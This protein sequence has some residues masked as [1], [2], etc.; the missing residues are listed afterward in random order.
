MKKRKYKLAIL[1]V[2]VLSVFLISILLVYTY[3]SGK[4]IDELA[5]YACNIDRKNNQILS[6]ELF[7]DITVETANSWSEKLKVAGNALESLALTV[8]KQLTKNSSSNQNGNGEIKLTKEKGKNYFTNSSQDLLSIFYWGR[9]DYVPQKIIRQLLSLKEK[10]DMFTGVINLYPETFY[11]VYVLSTD[12]FS[13]TYPQVNKYYKNIKDKKFFDRYYKFY[14]FPMEIKDKNIK[15]LLPCQFERPYRDISGFITMGV[16]V[17]IYDKGKMIALSSM[18]FNFEKIREA[19]LRSKLSSGIENKNERFSLESFFFLLSKGGSIITFPKQYADLFSL[20]KN[21]LNIEDFLKENTVNFS[22][23]RDPAIKTLGTKIA[24]NDFGVE[25]ITINNQA[26]MIAFATIKETGWKLGYVIKNESLLTSTVATEELINSNV[27]K[28]FRSY[29]WI[30]AILFILSFLILYFIFRYYVLRP[31]NRIKKGIC[32]MGEGNFNINLKEEGAAE[33]VELSSA[34]NY[35]GKELKDYMENLKIEITARQDF[36]TEIKIAEK[37]QRS[38][39]P[40]AASF[41]TNGNFQLVSRLNPAKNVSGDFY[42]FFYINDK[43]MALIIA[44]VSGKSLQAAF[45]MATSKAL[46]KNLCLWEP[47]ENPGNVLKEV[48]KSLCMDNKAQMFVT[49]SLIFYNI[50]DGTV[51]YANAGHH[52][53]ILVRDSHIIRTGNLNNIAL[54]I[55]NDAEYETCSRKTNVDDILILY[56][57]GIPEAISLKN[58]EYGEDRLEKLVLKNKELSLNELCDTIVNDVVSFEAESRFDDITLLAFK[59]SK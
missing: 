45:F 25:N 13:F 49:V 9:S 37:I 50:E 38:I 43:K 39:L 17:P 7:L 19:M 27:K 12:G 40:D 5:E 47:D 48:N 41:P 32:K 44:D 4:I 42:D 46:I 30:I 16:K 29:L 15:L 34:F 55:L 36:E 28:K 22:D 1:F 56:T 8:H 31:I 51:S 23:S 33:I 57:D 59:R 20:Q 54:G 35:L 2:S 24:N 3:S 53:A 52:T 58:E 18:D 6:S 26:Y 11:C 14:D 10:T 21:N